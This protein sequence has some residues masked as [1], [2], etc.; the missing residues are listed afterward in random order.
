MKKSRLQLSILIGFIC[1][2]VVQPTA[3]FAA[4]D[5]WVDGNWLYRQKVTILNVDQEEDLRNFSL[6]VIK[7]AA[8]ADFWS[9][10]N[11]TCSDIRFTD[12][13][14]ETLLPYRIQKCNNDTKEL[15]AWV[16]VPQI[17]IRSSDDYI[18]LYYGNEEATANTSS[19]TWNS[20]YLGVWHLDDAGNATTA[21]AT[22]N[23]NNGTNYGVTSASGKLGNAARFNSTGYIEIGEEVTKPAAFTMST[24]LKPQS[25]FDAGILFAYRESPTIAYDNRWGIFA[26]SDGNLGIFATHGEDLYD[27]AIFSGE[28][29]VENYPADS[30]TQL[31][32]TFLNNETIALYRN[33]QLIGEGNIASGVSDNAGTAHPLR[34][35]MY[36]IG[37]DS[38]PYIGD[39]DEVRVL[40][41]AKSA[42]WV[43]ASYLNENNEFTTFSA[44][45]SSLPGQPVINSAV[46]DNTQVTV[47]FTPPEYAGASAITSYVV[48][49]SPGGI[50]ATGAESPIVVSGLTPGVTY[51]F[52]VSAVNSFGSSQPS[53]ASSAV[54][55]A[56]A[57]PS[58]QR[59]AVVLL[60]YIQQP[61]QQNQTSQNSE[62]SDQSQSSSQ[63]QKGVFSGRTLRT[64]SR[65]EE[66]KILQKFL[67]SKGFPVASIGPGSPGN[68]TTFFGAQT[69]SALM[70]YQQAFAKEILVPAKLTRPTGMLATFTISHIEK[71]MTQ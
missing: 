33:G 57:T 21:D 54:T 9:A 35:G 40:S 37:E 20:D 41:N 61:N 6:L 23:E 52:T 53:D 24:W 1:I 34:F 7:T 56:S 25:W 43:R 55:I 64:G 14:G 15:L 2:A 29:N 26:F 65:G 69:R 47:T 10:V 44:A 11:T 18:Y 4:T 17:D 70:K 13:D 31:T 66:V 59:P 39:M 50:T 3:V 71:M 12:S 16:K 60:R 68:E 8:D 32:A 30:W 51:T 67:N 45:E 48:T 58:V 36:T 46:A 63:A 27:W 19:A 28:W 22:A 38:Y 5:Q 49:S 42:D 62:T